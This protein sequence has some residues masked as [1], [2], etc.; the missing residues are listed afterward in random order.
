MYCD[1]QI[2]TR[3]IQSINQYRPIWRAIKTWPE[4]TP[5]IKLHDCNKIT[6]RAKTAEQSRVR[7][8]SPVGWASIRWEGFVEKVMSFDCG[9]Q[10][11]TSIGQWWRLPHAGEK[12]LIGRIP[13]RNWTQLHF[14]LCFTVNSISPDIMLVLCRK[15]HLFVGK[16]AK[17]CCHQSCSFWLKYAPNSLSAETSPQ[18]PGPWGSCSAPPDP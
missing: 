12:L 3:I 11:P 16:S 1:V 7:E 5:G 13:M 4:A 8:G 15:L 10:A 2:K 18:T 17:N 6:K 9:I 14:C